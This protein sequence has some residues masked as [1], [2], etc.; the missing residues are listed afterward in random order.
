LI[1]E[2]KDNGLGISKKNMGKVFD[3]FFRGVESSSGPRLGL[4]LVKN[5]V[6]S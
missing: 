1:L 4:Y 5:V 6:F 3:M 2:L